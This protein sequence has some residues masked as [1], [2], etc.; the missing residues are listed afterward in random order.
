MT[1]A[2]Y[3]DPKLPVDKRVADL[4][5]RMTLAEKVAQL[6]S[7][8]WD[9]NRLD[10]PQTHELSPAFS[11]EADARRHRRS[12]PAERSPRRAR[13]GRVCEC[14]PEVSGRK[15]A[16]RDPGAPARGGAARS[17]GAGRHQLPAGHRPGGDVRSRPRRADLR[18]GGAPGAGPRRAA[19]AGPGHRRRPR[20]AL[21]TDRGDLRR[22]PVPGV[23]DGGGGDRRISGSPGGGRAGRR[24]ARP[25]D[26]QALR[27]PRDARR[28]AQRGA[29][30]LLGARR[31]ARSSCRPSRR[32]C[33]RRTW[34]P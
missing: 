27:R 14:R 5:R 26:G 23:A 6:G 13:R 16:P 20:P 25:G 4:L 19:R 33:A 11:R 30:K 18:G 32:P 9:Q 31:C 2:A 15:D 29:G 10:D 8:N 24:A 21:G 3:R 28:R 22:G 17:R 1:G 7:V 34:R 12:H